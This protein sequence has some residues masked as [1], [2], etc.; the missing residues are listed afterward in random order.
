[1]RRQQV[2]GQIQEPGGRATNFNLTGEETKR[3]YETV[4]V[5]TTAYTVN[6]KTYIL[7]DDDTAGGAVT[8]TLPP[9]ISNTD[10]VIHVKK[11]G[12]TGNVILDG[13]ASETIDGATTQT[14][15]TQY[16]SYSIV[17]SGDAWHI[18]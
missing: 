18:I 17:C 12:T 13:N 9:V 8:I 15:T 5:T 7:V 2:I 16:N 1:M 6:E 10:K 3:E 4:T 11:L 14:I